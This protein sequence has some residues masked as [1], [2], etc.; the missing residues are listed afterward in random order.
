VTETSWK[1][2]FSGDHL[3]LNFANSVSQRHTDSP[4]E[5]LTSYDAMVD[6]AE[7]ADIVGGE[8]AARLR[9]WG[10]RE[11][12]A[13]AALVGQAI[14]LR[15][16]LHRLFTAVAQGRAPDAA[17]LGMLNR[18]WHRLELDGSL[19]WRW[20]AGEDAPD[21]LI[22]RVVAAAVDLLTSGRRDRVR[23][24]QAPDCIWLF[25]DSS[26]NRSRRW[27]DMN[28]CGNRVKARRFYR[29]HSEAHEG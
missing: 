28:E 4:I 12:E 23:L 11:P 19:R 25:L 1:F 6:F 3:A 20:D 22:G 7:Q 26:K 2:D 5:R 10:R 13:A 21:A 16:S 9:G 17:D 29:R 15:E 27:C 8:A 24:C 18:W 14:E